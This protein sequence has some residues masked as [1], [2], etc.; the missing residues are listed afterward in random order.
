[1]FSLERFQPFGRV[2]TREWPLEP[3]T[4]GRSGASFDI[5]VFLV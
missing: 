1:M 2:S 5:A 4:R 3:T